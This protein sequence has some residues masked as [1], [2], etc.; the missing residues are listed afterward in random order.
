MNDSK[1]TWRELMSRTRN[2]DSL[3]KWEKVSFKTSV[4]FSFVIRH[5]NTQAVM[6]ENSA[7]SEC[8]DRMTGC[9]RVYVGPSF[10]QSFSLSL[11]FCVISLVACHQI[12]N[13]HERKYQLKNQNRCKEHLLLP[14]LVV[15]KPLRVQTN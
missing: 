12:L 3:Q 6:Q 4:S 7:F 13:S 9:E 8:S 1:A 2:H 11:L 5:R 10:P 14:W 15:L